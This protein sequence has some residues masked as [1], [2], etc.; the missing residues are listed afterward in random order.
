MRT[1]GVFLE[2]GYDGATLEDL[3][4]AM[5][6]I[7]APSFYAA[8]GSKEQ[9]FREAVALYRDSVGAA[10]P[11]AL[12]LPRVRDAIEEM[13]RSAA[14][15]FSD[16]SG[17]GGC[18]MVLGALNST[19]GNREVFA[20]LR[21]MRQQVPLMI[22]RRLERGVAEGE[23]PR[24]LDLADIASFYVTVLHGLAIRARDGATRAAMMAAVD[25]AMAAWPALTAAP[26]ARPGS[27]RR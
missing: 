19:R 8:F 6:G 11:R 17:P 7:A 25:G 10:G 26:A 16:P 24:G 4:K 1:I 22:R 3:Q 14:I 23:L 13:L 15:T 27:R 9:L 12:T 2:H 21:Q 20:E 18:L 5:G